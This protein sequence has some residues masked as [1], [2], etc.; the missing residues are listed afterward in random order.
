MTQLHNIN[1]TGINKEN[2][3]AQSVKYYTY[4]HLREQWLNA[5]QLKYCNMN[6]GLQSSITVGTISVMISRN[7]RLCYV[8][9]PEG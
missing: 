4:I 1:L 6:I 5:P 7:L 3:C 9:L 8:L 2:M